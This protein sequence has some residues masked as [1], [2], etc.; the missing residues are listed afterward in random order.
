[1]NRIIKNYIYN[2]AYQIFI[3]LVPLVTAP[4]LARVLGAVNLG[5][6]TYINSSTSIISTVCLLGIY[7]YGNRQTA[8]LRMDQDAVNQNFWEL[9]LT[10][11]F[12][13]V[14]GTISFLIYGSISNY[15]E[16]FLLYLPYLL[17]FFIDTSWLFVGM[18][19]MKPA[20]FKNFLAKLFGVICIFSFVKKPE[21]IWKYIFILAISTFLANLL[22]CSQLRK[23]IKTPVFSLNNVPKHIKE[24]LGLFL[25][26]V[27]SLIYLQMDKV[28]LEWL[29]GET[30][31]ISFYNQAE[32]IVTIPMTLIT[33]LSTVMMPRLAA[34]FK[35]GD[36]HKIEGLLNITGLF[37]MFL[38]FP[39]MFG[40]AS[41][42]DKLIPW[43][44]G[45]EFSP[46]IYAIIML[47]PLIVLNT[48]SGL[49]GSQYFTATNQIGILMKAYFTAAI[50][51]IVMNAVLIP[52]YG[53]VGAA[54]ATLSSSLVSVV[55]QYI[56][57]CRQINLRKI[58]IPSTKYFLYS[59]AMAAIIRLITADLPPKVS[60]T[61]LQVL[62]GI[63]VYMI[64]LIVTK[65]QILKL[66]ATLGWKR[67]FIRKKK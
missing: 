18:E 60:T 48:L 16:Y 10:R 39:M 40:I 14:I 8:Y 1:M 19:D 62:I 28:M 50:C 30:A 33:V 22:V 38:A 37:S 5:I 32:N 12:L 57:F 61:C 58:M 15:F 13:G 27:A 64:M 56:Y 7:T 36:K 17:A 6:Y 4:Y 23:Y 47:S 43:Y 11:F 41:I 3:L 65:D 63:I 34:E 46:T 21:D 35:T 66:A 31:Q 49:S 24:S 52:N 9:M 29:T 2:F 55:V 59:V 51:N 20:V 53:Y 45:S 42:A 44:L 25:P 54:A 26:Q 67:R